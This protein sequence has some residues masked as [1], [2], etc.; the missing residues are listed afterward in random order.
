MQFAKASQSMLRFPAGTM[1]TPA[2]HIGPAMR[3]KM[4]GQHRLD[5]SQP[6]RFLRVE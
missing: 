6:K 3:G 5:S 1:E 2:S 4:Q